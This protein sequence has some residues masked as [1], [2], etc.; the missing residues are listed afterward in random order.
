MKRSSTLAR[1]LGYIGK[2]KLLLPVALLLALVSVAL[3]LY[4]PVLIGEAIDLIIG[5][6]SVDLEGVAKKLTLSALLIGLGALAS[7]LLGVVNN[8]IAFHVMRDI[9]NDAFAKIERLPL[10][11]RLTDI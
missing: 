5:E 3:S 2:Y 4:V 1:V 6:G 9:R 11:Y 8:R 10:S 7:W